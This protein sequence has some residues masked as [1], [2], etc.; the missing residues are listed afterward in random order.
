MKRLAVATFVVLAIALGACT[1]NNGSADAGVDCTKFSSCDTCTA[2]HC[3]WCAD[4]DGGGSCSGG[5]NQCMSYG[6]GPSEAGADGGGSDASD[7]QAANCWPASADKLVQTSTI[8][9]RPGSGASNCS[10]GQYQLTCFGAPD[11]SFIPPPPSM[12]MCNLTT[13]PSGQIALYYCCP[14][15]KK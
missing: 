4:S 3:G 5:A 13:S 14:C 1:S 15:A 9:C 10:S 11:P 7:G 12:L 6:C 8:G 2:A